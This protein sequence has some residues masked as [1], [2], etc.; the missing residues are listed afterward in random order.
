MKIAVFDTHR[1]ERNL[2]EELNRGYRYSVT[3][4]DARLTRETAALAAGYDVACCFANDKVDAEALRGLKAGGVRLVATRTAGFNHINVGEAGRLGIRVVRVPAYSPYSVAEHATCLMLALDRK[5]HRAFARVRE[6]NFSL[7]GLVGFDLHGTT[8][9]VVGTGK[10]GAV[11]CRIMSGFG[12]RVL[13][14]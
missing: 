3:F 14:L 5:I 2:F 8:V 1:F 10:I 4:F 12:C 6:H 13:A 11:L 7:D 9:G